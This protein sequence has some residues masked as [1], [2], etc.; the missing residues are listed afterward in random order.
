MNVQTASR[1]LEAESS[2]GKRCAGHTSD[3]YDRPAG[4]QGSIS[5]Q[6]T[7]SAFLRRDGGKR[8]DQLVDLRASAM[9]TGDSGLFY[10]RHVKRL[11][12]F[13]VAVLAMK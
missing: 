2:P 8:R 1:K 12:E 13:L 4:R 11:S 6:L 10:V 5:P 7:G 9:G 3:M